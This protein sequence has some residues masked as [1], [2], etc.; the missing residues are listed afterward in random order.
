MSFF[1]N[2]AHYSL[3]IKDHV[4]RLVELKKPT[5]DSVENFFEEPVP[6]GLIENGFIMNR[7]KLEDLLKECVK[8]WKLRGK[9]V[10]IDLPNAFAVVRKLDLP[11]HIQ[12]NEIRSYLFMEI[13]QSIHLPFE[14]PI[15]DLHILQQT[16]GGTELLLFAAPENVVI[17]YVSLLEQCGLKPVAAEITPLSLF[18][19][20]SSLDLAIKNEN[21]MFIQFDQDGI[22]VSIFKDNLPLFIRQLSNDQQE[23]PFDPSESPYSEVFSEIERI[24]NF[25]QFTVNNGSE[26]VQ[27]VVITGDHSDIEDFTKSLESMIEPPIFPLYK[28]TLRTLNDDP[29]SAHY[30]V[31]LGLALKE[32]VRK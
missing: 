32:V 21:I 23:D 14:N 25:Y 8:K 15:F 20:Y 9:K 4:I 3:I 30:Q 5:P 13:G 11:S 2:H 6:E 27:K 24:M 28:E 26:P 31:N 1:Q 12:P 19:L 7:G 17:G 29:V 22:N 16:E 18:R 10:L